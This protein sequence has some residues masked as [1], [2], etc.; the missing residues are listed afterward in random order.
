MAIVRLFAAPLLVA[1]AIGLA[2]CGSSGPKIKDAAFVTKCVSEVK[3]SAITD[4]QKQEICGCVQQKAVAAGMGDAADTGDLSSDKKKELDQE[5]TACTTQVVAGAAGG[6]PGATTGTNT[7]GTNT[8]G[9]DTTGGGTST[10][11]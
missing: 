2:A 5:T 6:S 1:A 3:T 10:S 11:P 7:T 9:T 8:T 4:A